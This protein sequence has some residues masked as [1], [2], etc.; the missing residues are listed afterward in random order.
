MDQQQSEILKI[1]MRRLLRRCVFAR[2]IFMILTAFELEKSISLHMLLFA[3]HNIYIKQ[4]CNI[5]LLIKPVNNMQQNILKCGQK[6]IKL[7]IN[8]IMTM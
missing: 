3:N 2:I 5:V 8:S 4:H 6:R 1:C 7:K